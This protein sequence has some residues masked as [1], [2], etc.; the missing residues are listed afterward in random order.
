MKKFGNLITAMVTPFKDDL[1]VDYDQA[2]QL[3]VRLVGSGSDGVVVCGTTGESPTLSFEEKVGLYQAVTEAIGGKAVV[4]AGTGSYDT[5]SSIKLTQ[6][7][8]KVGVDGI[9]LVVPYYNKPPQEGLYQH[10]KEIAQKTELPVMLYNVPGRTSQNLLPDTIARLT[11]LDNVVAVKE[12]SGNMEQ[13]AEIRRKTPENFAI[14]SGDDS[15]TL[16]IM[17]VGG[18]GVVSVASH[19][20]G[21]RMKEMIK[22]FLSGDV[23]EATRIHLE[24]L[25]LFKVMFIT[26]NPIPVKTAVN[27]S[28]FKAGGLRLPLVEPTNEQRNAIREC[29]RQVGLLD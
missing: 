5:G 10:F 28:G 7:A 9:M 8:E 18:I 4:I 20:V 2:A 29:L 25:P 21:R 27:L 15:L 12:A 23:R 17:S 13:V 24:L 22:S 16:P 6:A 3:A 19:L 1:S 11:E 14:Y 26:T